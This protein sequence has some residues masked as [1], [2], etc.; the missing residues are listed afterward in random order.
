MSHS[1][2]GWD[3]RDTFA[4]PTLVQRVRQ[5]LTRSFLGLQRVTHASMAPTPPT[6]TVRSPSRN[7]LTAFLQPSVTSIH[8]RASQA[9]L[10]SDEI[11][12]HRIGQSSTPLP[13][14]TPRY[15]IFPFIQHQE[16]NSTSQLTNLNRSNSFLLSLTLPS[17][18]LKLPWLNRLS[19]S[20]H[21][22]TEKRELAFKS[23]RSWVRFH[24]PLRLQKS[25]AV[26]RDD[27]KSLMPEHPP[28]PPSG[29]LR[30][31]CV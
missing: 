11:R 7:S 5:S 31:K 23:A 17:P 20:T 29:W 25:G 14:N 2:L 12:S 26:T 9:C 19:H 21:S 4:P 16:S 15:S 28:I 18:T 30:S 24:L 27:E 1:W 22:S 8:P 3:Y 6:T 10:N 13:P